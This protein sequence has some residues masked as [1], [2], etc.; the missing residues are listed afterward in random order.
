VRPWPEVVQVGGGR[1][2]DAESYERTDAWRGL[3]PSESGYYVIVR[4]PEAATTSGDARPSF[5]GLSEELA[6]AAA[7][8]F[9]RP[10]RPLRRGRYG[11]QLW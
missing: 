2:F 5:V 8:G 7:K 4:R 1:L 11:A 3:F 10:P 9:Q 6:I